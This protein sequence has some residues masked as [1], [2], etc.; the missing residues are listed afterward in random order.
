LLIKAQLSA[1]LTDASIFDCGNK[2]GFLGANVALGMRDAK[3]KRY[4]TKLIIK[5]GW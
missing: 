5:N 2:E 3:T 4:L 1:V